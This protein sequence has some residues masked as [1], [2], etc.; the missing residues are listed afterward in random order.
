MTFR[1]NERPTKKFNE[2]KYITLSKDETL[3]VLSLY[4]TLKSVLDS[5]G[6]SFDIDLGDLRKLREKNREI[7]D[8]FNFRG[9]V[10]ENGDVWHWSD[11]VL[12]D[13]DDAYYYENLDQ[14][15]TSTL[16]A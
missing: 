15:T 1:N 16:D 9:K 2:K 10:R 8:V 13:D 7:D 6:E 5:V 12:P 11:N 4:N 3:K 14:I